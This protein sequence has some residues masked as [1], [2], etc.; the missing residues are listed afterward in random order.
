MSYNIVTIRHSAQSLLGN[1]NATSQYGDSDVATKASFPCHFVC[2]GP[3]S[4]RL[5]S[6]SLSLFI[7][8]PRQSPLAS[9]TGASS[10]LYGQSSPVADSAVAPPVSSAAPSYQSRRCRGVAKMAHK[11][12]GSWEKLNARLCAV[13]HI[14]KQ[15]AMPPKSWRRFTSGWCL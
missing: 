9:H 12:L 11:S 6:A 13:F 5:P 7:A 2:T 4:G 3:P 10:C 14:I 15:T 8:G 1:S